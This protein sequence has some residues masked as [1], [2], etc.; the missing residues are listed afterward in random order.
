MY[1]FSMEIYIETFLIQNILINFC[2]LKL[3]HLTTKSKTNFLKLLTSSF[4][5]AI[6]SVFIVLFLN[7]V[8]ILNLSKLITALLMLITAFKQTKKQFI[9]K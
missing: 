9:Y 6:P 1:N 5:G 2:L 4:L 7:N 3:V 8:L